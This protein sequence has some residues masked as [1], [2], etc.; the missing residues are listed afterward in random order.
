MNSL[1]SICLLFTS[2]WDDNL[3]YYL[4]ELC[5]CNWGYQCSSWKR[6]FSLHM[7][8]PSLVPI[9]LSGL[10]DSKGFSLVLNLFLRIVVDEPS[11]HG[12]ISSTSCINGPDIELWVFFSSIKF[13]WSYRD[14][15][16]STSSSLASI[17]TRREEI[18][19]SISKTVS[20]PILMKTELPLWTF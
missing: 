17:K 5:T 9:F 6:L 20:I 3:L 14:W 1:S 15:I 11:Y 2:L 7:D 10:V 18:S 8:H 13:N 4:I 12:L 16:H 19:T